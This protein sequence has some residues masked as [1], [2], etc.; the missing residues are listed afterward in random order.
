MADDSFYGEYEDFIKGSE[1]V[2]R[3]YLG[4]LTET[5]QKIVDFET[6]AVKEKMASAGTGERFERWLDSFYGGNFLER[7][8]EWM[9]PVV[10]EV[11]TAAQVPALEVLGEKFEA[12]MDLG[13]GIFASVYTHDYGLRHGSSSRR[14]ILAVIKNIE[15]EEE[16]TVERRAKELSV[17]E[18]AVLQRISEWRERRAKI[19][20][21]DEKIREVAAAMRYIWKVSDVEKLVWKANPN[22]C[23]LCRRM[24]GRTVSIDK[25]FLKDGEVLTGEYE[26]VLNIPRA[27]GYVKLK[28]RGAKFNPP[29]HKGCVCHIVPKL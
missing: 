12:G 15:E 2:E 3:R 24:D 14:Q 19:I 10:K 29:I 17:E 7:A 20:G 6:S 22:A 27:K 28:N 11:M 1:S 13:I 5:A 25:P 4:R 8:K 18:L 21:D 16:I 23:P 9:G 26:K